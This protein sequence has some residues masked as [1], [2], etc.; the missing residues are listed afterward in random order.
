MTYVV[1]LPEVLRWSDFVKTEGKQR[2]PHDKQEIVALTRFRFTFPNEGFRPVTDAGKRKLVFTDKFKLTIRP[3]AKV[4]KGLDVT[5]STS[6][7]ILAHEQIHY[8]FGFVTARALMNELLS[9][10][11]ANDR[12]LKQHMGSALDLHLIT[13]AKALNENY[14][15]DTEHGH[16]ATLQRKWQAAMKDCLADSD[17]TDLMGM[18]L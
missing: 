2:D 10:Q 14:D 18:P 5:D 3:V 12:L 13:R 1:R 7:A 16:N 4:W 15:D 8:L 6:D 9:L 11:V 17:A